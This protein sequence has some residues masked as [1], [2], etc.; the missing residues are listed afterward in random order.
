M[1]TPKKKYKAQKVLVS[2]AI[3]EKIRLL[4]AGKETG[5]KL[6]AEGLPNVLEG[7]RDILLPLVAWLD[8]PIFH[9]AA[10]VD[11]PT[12][13]AFEKR[14]GVRLFESGIVDI[15]L[16]RSGKWFLRFRGSH[17]SE[18]TYQEMDSQQLAEILLQKSD[19]FLKKSLRNVGILEG[20]PFL[21]DVASYNVMFLQFVSQCFK[22]VKTLIEE[23]E[24]R[25]R[26]MK[27]WLGLL[28]E[29]NQSLDPLVG[30]GKE[31]SMKGYSIF[32]DHSRGTSRCTADYFCPEALKPFW[33]VLKNRPIRSES[34]Y[35][36]FVT[37][38]SFDSLGDLLQRL[39]WAFDEIEKTNE[40]ADAKDLFGRTSG[41][42]P[43]TEG[44]IAVLKKL[45][46]SITI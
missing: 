25:L 1:G 18:T 2:P 11:C 27:D 40:G 34:E 38:F 41:R 45:V 13:K 17:R 23:R 37:E 22:S 39:S 8:K 32:E 16:E 6:G 33:K 7:L 35:R 4:N 31:I 5:Q 14:R 3:A 29:F 21:K 28:Y 12:P 15:W 42:F 26:I 9:D 30:H 36:K 24:K 44:E 20:I 43:F 10:F 46:D 19:D